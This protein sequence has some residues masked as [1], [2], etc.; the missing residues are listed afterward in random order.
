MNFRQILN[1]V[2]PPFSEPTREKPRDMLFIAQENPGLTTAFLIGAQHALLI[3]TVVVYSVIAG[4][5]VGLSD[6]E[7]RGFVSLEIVV[8]GV[9]TF[10]QSLPTRFGSGHLV[11]HSPNIIGMGVFIA[12]ATTFGLG[13]AAGALIISGLV[14]IFLSNLLPRFQTLFPAEVTGILLVLLGASMVEGGVRR[15]TGID[16]GSIQLDAVFVA[17]ATLVT[18]IAVS[19]WTSGKV[20]AF[21]MFAG[22]VSG[23]VVAS[24]TGVFG[25]KELAVVAEQPLMAFPFGAF[26]IPSPELVLAALLPILLIEVISAVDSIGTG[27]AIDR[28]NNAKWH[29]AHMPTV[30]RT[31]ACHGIGVLLHGLTGTMSGGTSSA[32]L[33]LAH[34]TGVAARLV[35]TAAGIIL[36]SIAFIPQVST[37][38]IQLPQPVVGAI[39]VYAAGYM[40][41]V[42]M[43][44]ILSRLM[45]HRRSFMVGLSITVGLGVLVLPELT[46]NAPV[47]LKPIL[48]SALTMGVVTAV[49]LNQIF[50]IGVS[51]T[52][53][54]E[55]DG[56][57]VTGKATRF[58]EDCGSSWGARRD[59]ISRAGL[60]VGEA[61]EVLNSERMVE[62]PVT[63]KAKFDEYKLIIALDYKGSRLP[64]ADQGEMD[65][66]TFFEDDD[67]DDSALDAAMATMSSVL[68]KNLADKVDSKEQGERAELRLEF[69][70]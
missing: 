27:V 18:I 28:M 68:V 26:E 20:R 3:L 51:Q 21:A 10:I 42:G 65:L 40:V 25:Q 50:R 55:L 61:L 9:A 70:H 16:A 33:G 69:S 66:S 41:V 45:N 13:A 44:L 64:L 14:V 36:V 53:Q 35:G 30:S 63:L 57:G 39:I 8:L 59:V 58:L 43:E 5:E 37:F 1:A 56:F 49:I 29:R 11:V 24:V 6:A 60:S 46:A 22:L 12:V 15:F 4:R 19:I 23:L 67:D 32:S 7:L 62:G 54:L 2:F 52:G 31:V 38:M 47:D 48:G 34:M 17:S